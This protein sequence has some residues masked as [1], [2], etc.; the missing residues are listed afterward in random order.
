ML[1]VIRLLSFL[2]FSLGL[3]ACKPYQSIVLTESINRN[4]QDQKLRLSTISEQIHI[5]ESEK[6][7]ILVLSDKPATKDVDIFWEIEGGDS[8]FL[9]TTEKSLLEKGKSSFSFKIETKDDNVY[10]GIRHYNLK[11]FGGES[12]V[13]DK[14]LL[15]IVVEDDDPQ[16]ILTFENSTIEVSEGDGTIY[17]PLSINNSLSQ[18]L[19]VEYLVAGS[20]TE[21]LDYSVTGSGL[22]VIPAGQTTASVEIHLVDDQ[23]LEG[24]ESI[25]LTIYQTSHPDIEI[26]DFGSVNISIIDNDLA[27]KPSSA[28]VL[29]GEILSFDVIGGDGNY[30]FEI[31][32]EVNSIIAPSTGQMTAALAPETFTVRVTDGTGLFSES[33]VEVFNF[34]ANADLGLWLKADSIELSDNG[35]VESWLDQTTNANNFTQSTESARPIYK[36]NAFNGRSALRFDGIDDRLLSNY[37]PVTGAGKRSVTTVLGNIHPKIDSIPFAWGGTNSYGNAFGLNIFS[38]TL[39]SSVADS[40]AIYNHIAPGSAN[41]GSFTLVDIDKSYIVTTEYDGDKV[42]FFINGEPR[43][44]ALVSLN[45]TTSYNMRIGSRFGDN[46]FY[47][48]DIAEILTHHNELSNAERQKL[49]CYL[50]RKYN[51]PI[52]NGLDCGISVLKLNHDGNLVVQINQSQTLQ[53]MGGAPPY[54]FKIVSG[55]GS[56]NPITGVYTAPSFAEVNRVL[57]ED[58]MGQGVEIDINV[59]QFPRPRSWLDLSV[60]D[61]KFANDQLVDFIPDKSGHKHG[62][63]QRADDYKPV[64][65]TPALNTHPVLE[66]SGGQFL[67]GG[68]TL[69]TG[70]NQRTLAVVVVNGVSGQVWGY[71]DSFSCNNK[72]ELKFNESAGNIQLERHCS[73][74]T[75]SAVTNADAKILIVRYTGTQLIIHENGA[76]VLSSSVT[77][78]TSSLYGLRLGSNRTGGGDYFTGQIAEF[79]AFDVSLTDAERESLESYLS[80]KFDISLD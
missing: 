10:H 71:G 2:F 18:D 49:E 75:S 44:S 43:A 33:T 15:D 27:M 38:R 64:F 57:V 37:L 70:A 69:P 79:M 29:P 17:V 4:P 77:P 80:Q 32:Q 30:S 52:Y 51:I 22:V 42:N 48:G 61:G 76:Q 16:Y 25:L 46:G 5:T 56:I 40:F 59:T 3:F 62:Y 68:F 65:K 11:I 35:L 58:R 41:R 55:S 8:D 7:T 19:S 78:A 66:F 21:G 6:V 1:I 12:D 34:K 13:E 53:V 39:N 74:N 36:A 47:K 28:I 20:A 60:V 63:A 14:V 31:L 73:T 45:T 23:V 9:S 26:G 54:A 24:P 67:S 50:A 72:F